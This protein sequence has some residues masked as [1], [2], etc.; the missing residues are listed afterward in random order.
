MSED[1]SKWTYDNPPVAG[2]ELTDEGWTIPLAGTDP[3]DGL[4]EVIVAIGGAASDADKAGA[5]DIQLVE[6]VST[7]VDAGDTVQVRVTY[8][9]NVDVTAGAT[10]DLTTTGVSGTITCTA[11]EQLNGNIVIFEGTVP[12]EAGSITLEAGSITGTIE[13]DIGGTASDLVFVA[14]DLGEAGPIV[15]NAPVLQSVAFTAGAAQGETLDVT[16]TYNED[17]DVTAGATL[18]VTTTG[19]GGNFNATAAEQLGT[20]TVVFSVTIPSETGDLTIATQ[21]ITGTIVADDNGVAAELNIDGTQAT[22]AG[23]VNIA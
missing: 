21:D 13:D 9:E 8:N 23:T 5:A 17:V 16:V 10:L 15:V 20:S 6:I 22:A 19:A 4:T 1:W 2:A 11:A 7:S 14:G 3:A 12:V 18:E